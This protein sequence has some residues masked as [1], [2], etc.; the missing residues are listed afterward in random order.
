MILLH[1]II[2]IIIITRL[3]DAR[4]AQS[5]SS[6]RDARRHATCDADHHHATH[7]RH[8]TTHIST[9]CTIIITRRTS[10]RD[11]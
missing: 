11:V 2:V 8:H 6:P 1:G 10:S 7:N 3:R 4:G 9:Q 5:S